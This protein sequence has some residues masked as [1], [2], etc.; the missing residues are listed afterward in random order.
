MIVNA[1]DQ[2]ELPRGITRVSPAA[3]KDAHA[4]T[5][6]SAALAA[7]K[8]APFTTQTHQPVIAGKKGSTK[9]NVRHSRI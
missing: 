1:V 7:V 6:L 2:V 5:S 8:V 9:N 4:L 3:I